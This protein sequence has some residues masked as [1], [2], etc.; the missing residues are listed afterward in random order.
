MVDGGAFLY[1]SHFFGL[2]NGKDSYSMLF[3][4][5][6]LNIVCND[7]FNTG[8]VKKR[9]VWKYDMNDLPE[10]FIVDTTKA[11]PLINILT[12]GTDELLKDSYKQMM[13]NS[14]DHGHPKMFIGHRYWFWNLTATLTLEK[15]FKS[16][17]LIKR[18][19]EFYRF[20]KVKSL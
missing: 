1:G 17:A 4:D 2:F 8:A 11:R 15:L 19:K 20:D 16:G 5:N 3:S 13:K 7:K 12:Q 18:Q 10:F 6:H 9:G 14:T